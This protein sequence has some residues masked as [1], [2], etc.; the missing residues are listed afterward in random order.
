MIIAIIIATI[1]I[2]VFFFLQLPKF[3]RTPTGERLKTIAISPNWKNGKFNNLSYTPNLTEGMSY[4]AVVKEFLFN[5]SKNLRP[6]ATLPSSQTD[7][8]KLDPDK[9]ILVW[10][11]HSSYF[12]Q[13]DGK[14]ILVDPVFSGAASPLEFTTKSFAG[15]DIYTTNDIPEIDYLFLSHDHWDHLD[16][17]TLVKLKQKIRKIICPLGTGEHLERWGF[18]TNRIIEKDWNQEVLLEEGFKVIVTPARHFS[19]RGLRRNRTL[20]VP[21]Y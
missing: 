21:I 12:M 1:V 5:K 6:P 19:G 13:V 20:W 2:A 15:S 10:F 8:L 14:K 18:D 17:E 9:N 16:Y 3:G 4:Y 7:L 11:G